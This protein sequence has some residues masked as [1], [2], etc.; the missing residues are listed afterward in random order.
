MGN[1]E[2]LAYYKLITKYL[3]DVIYELD[4]RNYMFLNYFHSII[5]VENII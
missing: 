2:D 4:E 3:N 5:Y 1:V